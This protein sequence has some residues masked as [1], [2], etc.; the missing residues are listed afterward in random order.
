MISLCRL[1]TAR[2]S[3]LMKTAIAV[4]V[5][6]AACG[7]ALY[8]AV[9][10][11]LKNRYTESRITSIARW[12]LGVGHLESV[13]VDVEYGSYVLMSDNGVLCDSWNNLINYYR[14]PSGFVLASAGSDETKGTKDDIALKY[15][16][17]DDGCLDYYLMTFVGEFTGAFE[18]E[19]GG[20]KVKSWQN[21]RKALRTVPSFNWMKSEHGQRAIRGAEIAKGSP[22]KGSQ[23]CQPMN[24]RILN[25]STNSTPKTTANN[26]P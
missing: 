11:D 25:D 13:V 3:V 10:I 14:T 23:R 5:L 15:R 7:V 24:L 16:W 20:A 8:H 4:I 2:N 1:W 21:G 22:T 18:G 17:A 26:P 6:I 19:G 9:N 12:I